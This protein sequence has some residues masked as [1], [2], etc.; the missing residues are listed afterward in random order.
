MRTMK[1]PLRE[2]LADT[3]IAAVTI[4]VL[5]LWALDGA[6]KA[7]WE[8]L[9]HALGFLFRAVAIFDIPYLSS[10]LTSR[11]RLSLFILGANFYWALVNFFAAWLLS[12]W[13]YGSGPLNTLSRYSK[14][15][16]GSK[17]V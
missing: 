6:F 15:I 1:R 8:P 17:N 2:T 4:A 5:L 13:V 16:S 11:D 14:N 12:R 9:S 3:H 7:L 10:T